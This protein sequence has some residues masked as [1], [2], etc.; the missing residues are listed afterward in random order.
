MRRFR[1]IAV[2]LAL[3]SAAVVHAQQPEAG[4]KQA[5]AIRVTPG[6]IVLDGRLNE[7]VWTKAPAITDFTQKDPVEGAAP[8][9][10]VEVSFAYDD[11]AL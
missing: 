7:D 1:W 5:R 3:G 8:S 10:R 2:A 11:T 6:V 4:R 9:D